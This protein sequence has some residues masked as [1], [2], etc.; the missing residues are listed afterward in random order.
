MAYGQFHYS[1]PLRRM[2]EPRASRQR[3]R[4]TLTT[5][6]LWFRCA[7]R[8][9]RAKELSKGYSSRKRGCRWEDGDSSCRCCARC[10]FW[11]REKKSAMLLWK[12]ATALPAHLLPCS[13]KRWEQRRESISET[14]PPDLNRVGVLL[15]AEVDHYRGGAEPVRLVAD[16]EDPDREPDAADRLGNDV[17]VHPNQQAK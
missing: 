6:A 15:I 7:R 16:V 4:A 10:S 11:R 3:C 13:A 12:R 2:R 1:C 8:P 9:G 17:Q 5:P 14:A